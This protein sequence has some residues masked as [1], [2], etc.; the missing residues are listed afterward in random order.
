MLT[1][2][3][4]TQVLLALEDPS[5]L[6]TRADVAAFLAALDRPGKFGGRYRSWDKGRFHEP[7]PSGLSLEQLEAL[8]RFDRESRSTRTALLAHGKQPMRLHLSE[9]TRAAV[10]AV[11]SFEALRAIPDISLPPAEEL[12][13][14]ELDNLIEEAFASS[15]IE[16]AVTS[17]RIA[18]DLARRK[19]QPKGRSEQMV[20]N[21]WLA[22]RRLSEWREQPLSSELICEIQ[23]VLTLDTGLAPDEVG[24]FRTADDI[25]VVDK[26]SGAVLHVPPPAVELDERMRRVCQ[27]AHEDQGLPGL[28]RA[29]LIHHQ[30]AFDHP[31]VDGNGCTAR[32][33]FL[34]EATR[35]PALAWLRWVPF[36]RAIA[37]RRES[38]YQ[39]FVDTAE[40]RFDTTHFVRQQLHC[41]AIECENLAH[42]LADFQR[43]QAWYQKQ[44]A[45]EDSLNER[46]VALIRSALEQDDQAFTQVEHALH[47]QVSTMTANRDLAQLVEWRLLSKRRDPR[48][49]RR[50]LYRP[51]DRLRELAKD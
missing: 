42:F 22:L 14:Y 8:V 47:H 31:F 28:V 44:L 23:A 36:S 7:K 1:D 13:S 21:N 34:L 20:L 49:G 24:A 38:Y 50:F 32:V 37:Q 29:I 3:Q 39:A 48:D 27:F 2:S 43:T 25:R 35:D 4:Y 40:E 12:F 15:A 6:L 16:G 5:E 19:R 45:L 17:R 30:L 10:T 9:P 11:A 18:S 26:T 46:Q 51:T 33:V 41:L